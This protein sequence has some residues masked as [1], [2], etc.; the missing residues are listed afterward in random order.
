MDGIEA[1]L[2]NSC[3][4]GGVTPLNLPFPYPPIKV[5]EENQFYANLLKLD[6]CGSVSELTAAVQYI[7]GENSLCCRQCSVAK[8]I[9]GMAVA[10]MTHLQKLGEMILLLGGHIDFS[11]KTRTG[12]QMWTPEYTNLANDEQKI[13]EANLASERAAIEQYKQHISMIEDDYVNALLERIIQDE[14]YHIMLL[15]MMKG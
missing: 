3:G 14:E 7:H 5:R 1:V 13:L 4:F 6:Y 10:E 9:V 8:T 11:I 2:Q 12:T 15:E